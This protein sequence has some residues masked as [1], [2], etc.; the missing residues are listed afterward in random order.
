MID[1]ATNGEIVEEDRPSPCP[2]S[3]RRLL[4]PVGVRVTSDGKTVYR[5]TRPVEPGGTGGSMAIRLE[6]VDYLLV[7]QRVWQM[8]F[9]PD[10]KL[11]L[12]HQ[13]Q[14][15]RHIGHRRGRNDKVIKS[16][17]VGEQPW[18]VVVWHRNER[19]RISER[20]QRSTGERH[21]ST[22]GAATALIAAPAGPTPSARPRPPR[23]ATARRSA[24]RGF[25]P[26][27]T[28]A[29]SCRISR[30]LPENRCR[31]NRSG[32][33]SPGPIT[34]DEHR[35]G[36]FARSLP[37]TGPEFFRAIWI[38]EVVINDLE[39]RPMALDSF[40]FDDEGTMRVH[41]HRHQAGHL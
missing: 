25:W 3:R 38:N 12:H 13:R 8:A 20:K 31:K 28:S 2:A 11:L 1:P 15:E 32:S 41:L 34:R 14:F 19:D 9:T 4:Q 10:E 30:W 35:L 21:A 40:E 24:L 26:S 16:I 23:S 22:D 6:V 33:F 27:A 5:G 7:G 17:P 18:G 36:R 29:R 37:L 39:I